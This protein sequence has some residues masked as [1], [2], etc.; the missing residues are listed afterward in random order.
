MVTQ[1]LHIYQTVDN[2]H[3]DIMDKGRRKW[4]AIIRIIIDVTLFLTMQYLSYRGHRED[5]DSKHQGNFLEAVK[6]IAE[7]N[8]VMNKRLSDIQVL[9]KRMSTYLSLNIQNQFI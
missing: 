1:R 5:V 7:Y 9:K 2:G 6:L 8:P 4:G 3:Q